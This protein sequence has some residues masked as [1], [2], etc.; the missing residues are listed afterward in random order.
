MANDD[1]IF[2]T[3]VVNPEV[4]LG[5]N[6]YA[7]AHAQSTIQMRPLLHKGS[8]SAY[9]RPENHCFIYRNR[10]FFT[11]SGVFFCC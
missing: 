3:G 5:N 11:V 7:G 2:I 6:M 4:T 8:I 9:R 10:Y 1:H